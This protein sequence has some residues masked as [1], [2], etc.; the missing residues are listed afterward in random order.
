M[1]AASP[2]KKARTDMADA[3]VGASAPLSSWVEIADDCHWTMQ[4]I[5]FGIFR[6]SSTDE[7]RCGTAIGNKV[8]GT[9]TNLLQD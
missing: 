7:P 1:A 3:S 6:P 4:N 8:R 5:P 2:T 9:R